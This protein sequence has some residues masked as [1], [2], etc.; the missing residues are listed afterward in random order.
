MIA[1]G[2]VL[3]LFAFDAFPRLNR[4]EICSSFR[5]AFSAESGEW[6]K[7]VVDIRVAE[8][9]YTKGSKYACIVFRADT[10]PQ[11]LQLVAM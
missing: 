9:M 5:L 4:C 7:K 1:L 10:D 11:V 3:N 2:T 8:A 6:R